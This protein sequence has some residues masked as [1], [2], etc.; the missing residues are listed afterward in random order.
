MAST[1]TNTSIHMKPTKQILEQKIEEVLSYLLCH[2]MAEIDSKKFSL[3]TRNYHSLC[4]RYENF[5]IKSY[6]RGSHLDSI[7]PLR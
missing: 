1:T 5:G 7:R 6:G 2:N 3:I 4:M